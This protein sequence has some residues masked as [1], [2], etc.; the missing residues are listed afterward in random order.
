M[1]IKQQNNNNKSKSGDHKFSLPVVWDVSCYI[2]VSPFSVTKE[3]QPNSI[4]I[5]C[6][7]I[8]ALDKKDTYVFMQ[9]Q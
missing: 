9:N 4:H 1:D 7:K 3:M 6:Q 5:L 2:N 8:R